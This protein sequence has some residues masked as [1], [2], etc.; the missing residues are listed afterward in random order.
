MLQY[1]NT[2]FIIII[3]V[4]FVVVMSQSNVTSLCVS[5]QFFV[6][7]LMEKSH[8][9]NESDVLTQLA[10]ISKMAEKVEE[11]PP[12][13]GLFTSDGRTEWAKAR[14]L[15]LKGQWSQGLVLK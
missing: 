3:V 4:L 5:P 15:L 10:K 6:L 1:V 11:K 14:D 8:R 7:Y 9:L 13:I 2:C 12:P